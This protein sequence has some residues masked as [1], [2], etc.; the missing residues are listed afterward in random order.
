[1]LS[2]TIVNIG[3]MVN[4][5]VSATVALASLALTIRLT[6]RHTWSTP[7]L[8]S[9]TWFWWFTTLVWGC[10]AVRYV[11]AG[12]G[13]AGEWIGYADMLVQASVFF[14]GP[15][16]FAFLVL[17]VTNSQLFSTIAALLSF[18]MGIAAL[19]FVL[20]PGGIPLND[21]TSFSAE[22]TVNIY[23]FRIFGIEVII[24]AALAIY[25]IVHRLR[26]RATNGDVY[27]ALLA[28]PLLLYLLLGSIDESKV[29]T[30]WP[31][32]VFRLLYVAG[33]LFVYIIITH[34]EAK[35]ESQLFV[36]QSEGSYANQ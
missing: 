28:A 30:S 9:Y 8:E 35:D 2:G 25:D 16:L 27:Q 3:I 5:F 26:N 20:R 6:R 19:A 33:F 23:S 4:A 7:A 10:S 29:I 32:V 31:L 36:T 24:L 14:G 22:A 17:R 12:L 15:A 1:M 13:Y 21:V 18:C 11:A 34:D